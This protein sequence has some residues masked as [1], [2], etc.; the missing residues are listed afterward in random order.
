MQSKITL[1]LTLL[2]I[3]STKNS[4]I[5]QS[6]R[7][8]QTVAMFDAKKFDKILFE[9]KLTK[10][11]PSTILWKAVTTFA[12]ARSVRTLKISWELSNKSY[13][14]RFR[15]IKQHFNV[16]K[17]IEQKSRDTFLH[18]SLLFVL[19]HFHNVLK[20]AL[21]WYPGKRFFPSELSLKKFTEV[22]F[23]LRK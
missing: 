8:W 4:V 20:Y 21:F 1:C 22:L 12:V 18:S 9:Y 11:Q 3:L 5:S 13:P 17:Y 10:S 14:V 7:K 19:K 16:E 23:K 2:I 15:K 6:G